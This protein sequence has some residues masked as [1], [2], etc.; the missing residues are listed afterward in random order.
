MERKSVKAIINGV[1]EYLT[2]Y[3]CEL[4]L[5]HGEKA[6]INRRKYLEQSGDFF[7][8]VGKEEKKNHFTCRDTKDTWSYSAT[9]EDIYD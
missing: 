6:V 8:S 4:Y 9:V 7:R 3:E 2:G 1:E 5:L